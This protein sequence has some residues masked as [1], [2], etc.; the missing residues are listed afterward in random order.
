MIGGIP[1]WLRCED[2]PGTTSALQ[3]LRASTD[4]GQTW[5]LFTNVYQR[6]CAQADAASSPVSSSHGSFTPASRQSLQ[7]QHQQQQQQRGPNAPSS[8]Q[9]PRPPSGL[10]PGGASPGG[11]ADPRF[12]SHL[13]A[14][15]GQPQPQPQ[16]H[17]HPSVGGVPLR[18]AE[19]DPGLHASAPATSLP[20]WRADGLPTFNHSFPESFDA[21]GGQNQYYSQFRVR[22]PTSSQYDAP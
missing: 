4:G 1:V 15:A 21:R 3:R 19:A 22:V 9:V 14:R 17:R 5:D 13:D 6:H 16:P 20:Q 12:R 2:V 8:R 11:W 10:S 7:Q 18:G